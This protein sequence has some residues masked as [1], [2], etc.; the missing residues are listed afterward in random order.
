MR[1]AIA[2]ATMKAGDNCPRCKGEGSYYMTGDA[3]RSPGNVPCS[4]Y[5]TRQ[6]KW[7]GQMHNIIDLQCCNGI[8]RK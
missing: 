4:F 7:Q 3:H 5:I 1:A 8:L 2:K 6:G